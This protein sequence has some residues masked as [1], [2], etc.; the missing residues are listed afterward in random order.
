MAGNTV[1]LGQRL[2]RLSLKLVTVLMLLEHDFTLA[3][4]RTGQLPQPLPQP[5]W[6]DALTCKP[7]LDTRFMQYKKHGPSKTESLL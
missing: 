6:N 4:R 7:C 2:A 1:C 5:N 3:D